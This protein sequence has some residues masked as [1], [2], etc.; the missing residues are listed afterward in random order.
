MS[1]HEAKPCWRIP[2][3]LAKKSEGGIF[4]EE[5][6]AFIVR[7]VC[8]RV[9]DDCQLGALLMSIKLR[10]MTDGETVSLTKA[11]RD[12]GKVMS[13]PEDW[14]V[15]DKHS[16]GG[17]G[18]KVSLALTPALA[19]RGVRVPMISGRGLAHTGGT[20]DK[21]ES[22]PG[23]R[24][25]MSER[26]IYDC[27][28]SVGCCIV[29]QTAD[30]V[31]AD[32]RMYAARDVTSTVP[33]MPLILSS[34]LSKKAAE[35]PKALV[36]DVKFGRGAFMKTREEAKKLGQKMVDVGNGVGMRTTALLTAMDV[37]IG[38]TIGNALE[39]REA[40][41]CLR[42]Q[43]PPDLHQLVTNLGGELLYST[44]LVESPSDGVREI[45]EALVSGDARATFCRML[46]KQGVPTAVAESLCGPMPDYQMLPSA[47]YV[48]PVPAHST[49]LLVDVDSLKL[50]M[51]SLALGAGRTKVGDPVNHAVGIVLLK[52]V[53]ERVREGEAWAELHHDTPLPEGSLQ[54]VQLS[55][56]I[57]NTF[58]F[59]PVPLIAA[60]LV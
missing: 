46:Q 1:C 55:A 28:N 42:G 16:T 39:V 3:L 33:S 52:V 5:E 13:W 17:V 20:L 27:M 2:D 14:P 51:L 34:I 60:K 19:A 23:F 32:R 49:G 30:I 24:A 15:V 40:L 43:G 22:I 38:K 48:T 41:D 12:S 58:S 50:A 6:I 53:G 4:S 9:I 7:S 37:P 36:L 25:S 56:H 11:M 45:H 44:G 31:P 29:G 57:Q 54:E 21:L 47:K 10:G 18:D 26:E 8:D 35:S 59:H